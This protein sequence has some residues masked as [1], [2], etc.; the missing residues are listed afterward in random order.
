MCLYIYI[1]IYKEQD[2]TEECTPQFSKFPSSATLVEAKGK[3]SGFSPCIHGYKNETQDFFNSCSD[4]AGLVY[5]H[6]DLQCQFSR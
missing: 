3:N 4:M 1:C 2:G 6:Y 5:H